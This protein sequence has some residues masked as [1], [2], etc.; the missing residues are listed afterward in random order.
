MRLHTMQCIVIHM[1]WL[2]AYQALEIAGLRFV[3]I[4]TSSSL[5]K[6]APSKKYPVKCL[7]GWVKF[8]KI[9]ELWSMESVSLHRFGYKSTTEKIRPLGQVEVKE[10]LLNL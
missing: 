4:L 2:D 7:L 8:L 5:F 10:G 6:M 9:L 1:I 3:L